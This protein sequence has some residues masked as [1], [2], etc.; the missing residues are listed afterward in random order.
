MIEANP[1]DGYVH[2]A[3]QRKNQHAFALPMEGSV[4]QV[5]L[6]LPA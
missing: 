3:L 4:L 1:G 6:H 2:V 5:D